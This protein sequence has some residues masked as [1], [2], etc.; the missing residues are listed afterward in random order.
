MRLGCPSGPVWTILKQD[1][2]LAFIRNRKKKSGSNRYI[3]LVLWS[4]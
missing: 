4:A 2:I 3:Y 1:E